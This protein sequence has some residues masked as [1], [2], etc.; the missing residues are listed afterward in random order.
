M[1][2]ATNLAK[3]QVT[4]DQAWGDPIQKA[5]LVAEV[6]ALR[7][8][9]AKQTARVEDI[10]RGSGRDAKRI[11]KTIYWQDFCSL[12][13]EDCSDECV[14]TS[15]TSD[16]SEKDI[17]ISGCKQIEFALSLKQFRTVPHMWDETVAPRLAAN[18]K[19][20]DEWLNAQ[21]IAFLE[22]NKG[23]HEYTLSVGSNDSQDWTIPAESWS[24]D[25]IPE[26]QLAARFARFGRPYLLDG[27]NLWA[28]V[29]QAGY[30]SQNADG[31]GENALL[32][33][34][35]YVFDPITMNTSAPNK[36]YLVN[37]S[38][39]ALA[40][41]NYWGDAPIE[42]APGHF[43]YRIQSRNLPGVYYDVHEI[44]ACGTNDFVSSFQIRVNYEFLL[45]P[46]GCTSTRTGILA[47]EKGA[48]A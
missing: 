10:I 36:T 15:A 32:N 13:P 34:F 28:K 43:V 40:T 8:Q 45:N 39:V 9:M 4:I 47:F 30:F 2:F 25:L 35:P 19:A 24:V 1:S 41:G 12:T 14:A 38:A 37:A 20:M 5:D 29:Y 17:T 22:A 46:V 3:V 21:F 31:K 44:R 33:T 11:T 48:G 26:L 16:D 42:M 23:N 6:E 7:M 27:T 18:M